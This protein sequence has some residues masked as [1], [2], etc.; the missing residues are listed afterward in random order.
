MILNFGIFPV[1][2]TCDGADTSPE[3]TI[4]GAKTPYLAIVMEDPD[5]TWGTFTHWIVWNIPATELIPEGLAA[6]SVLSEPVEAVQ[7]TNDSGKVGYT[8]PCP[9]RGE[10][11]R[12]LFRVYGLAGPLDLPPGADRVALGRAMGDTIRQYGE[13]FAAYG[14]TVEAGPPRC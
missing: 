1:E 9:L 3:I 7:G 10:S 4:L 14:R 12:Y 6:E 11:H 2:H 13:A 8:G 5:A